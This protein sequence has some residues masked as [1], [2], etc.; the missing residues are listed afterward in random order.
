M[1]M[2]QM[3]VIAAMCVG[4]YW[5]WSQSDT[6]PLDLATKQPEPIAA[7]APAATATAVVAEP[8]TST[9]TVTYTEADINQRLASFALEGAQITQVSLLQDEIVM[10]FSVAGLSSD[11]HMGVQ[12]LDG[13]VEIADPRIEG[14][15]GSMIPVE[16]VVDA[17]E[18]EINQ[19]IVEQSPISAIAVVPGAIEVT[20]SE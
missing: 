7:E 10:S 12:A 2:V 8:S 11:L 18:S 14:M 19:R 3:V 9:R 20:Y 4:A 1:K 17:I 15:L 13:R 16:Q 5:W 6:T